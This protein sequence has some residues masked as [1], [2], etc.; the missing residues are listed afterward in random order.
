MTEEET[1]T[2]AESAEST[3]AAAQDAPSNRDI[4][5][6]RLRYFL[7]GVAIVCV[8]G[9]SYLVLTRGLQP[10]AEQVSVVTYTPTPTPTMTLT[11]TRTPTPRP[12]TLTPTPGPSPT[13]LPPSRHKVGP[14]DTWLGLA[15]YYDVSLESLLQLNGETDSDYIQEGVEV[16][17]PYP[18]YTPTP[19]ASQVPTLQVLEEVQPDQCREHVIAAGETLIGI[20]LDYEVSVQLIK[21]VNSIVDADLVREGQKLCIPLVTPGPAPSPTFGPSPTPEIE[22]PYRAP[23]LLYPPAGI[24]VPPS[25]GGVML[26]WTVVDLLDS[27][28]YYMVELRNISHPDTRAVQGFVRTTTWQL[29]ETVRPKADRIETFAWRVSVVRGSS[30]PTSEDFRWER[31]GF[32]SDWQT[33][34]W[35]GVAA[36][37]AETPAP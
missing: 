6:N 25:S 22:P 9:A 19:D 16:L 12:P 34:M 28:E 2:P 23:Q 24:E 32:P 37:S 27:N 20:A 18:T 4:W 8:A 7:L 13:P 26:Q 3:P 35:M 21:E 17:I 1:T 10:P 29:P 30:E 36:E 11:P 31:S 5:S 33:F 14:G 15:I